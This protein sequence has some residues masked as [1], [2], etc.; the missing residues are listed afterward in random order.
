MTIAES[1]DKKKRS[2]GAPGARAYRGDLRRTIA[3]RRKAKDLAGSLHLAQ[4]QLVKVAKAARTLVLRNIIRKDK[5]SEE[6]KAELISSLKVGSF[7]MIFCTRL[8]TSLNRLLICSVRTQ[9][10]KR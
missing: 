7:E 8:N 9:A 10:I 4:K 1:L 3:R 6:K 5:Y 2:S